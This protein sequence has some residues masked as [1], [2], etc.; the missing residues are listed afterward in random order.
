[1]SPGANRPL[2]ISPLE[3]M[4]EGLGLREGGFFASRFAWAEAAV[5]ISLTELVG[6]PHD[7]QKRADSATSVAQ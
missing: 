1:M 7:G 6:S 2:E 3:E 4:C 5:G